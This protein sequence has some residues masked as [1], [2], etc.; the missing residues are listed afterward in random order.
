MEASGNSKVLKAS[1]VYVLV[2]LINKG[3]GIITVP[4]FTR[5]LSTAEMGVT[6]TWISWMTILLPITTLSLVTAS[7]YIAFKEYPDK[8]D[9]YQSS[10]LVLSTL[11]TFIFLVIYLI[12]HDILNKVFTLST[13]LM[14][15]MFLYLIFSPAL[16][17]WMLRQRYEYKT[18]QM[19]IVTLISNIMA[20][21]VAVNLVLFFKESNYNLGTLRVYGTYAVTGLFGVVFYYKILKDGR[22]LF[23]REFWK[24]GL[25]ISVPLIFHTLAKNLLDISDRSMISIFNG[26]DAVG[27]Y[28]TIYSISTLSLIVWTA[29]NNAFIPY[30]Y[31]KL[32]R[33]EKKGIADV[34]QISYIMIIIYGGACIILT[35]IAPEIVKLLT[36]DAY[37]E[38]VHIMPPVAAGIFLTCVYN[39]FANVILF[40]KKSVGVMVATMIA[41]VT[42]IV[43]NAI[44]IPKFGYIAAAYTTLVAYIILSIFQ[45]GVMKRV[46]KDSLYNMSL[47]SIIS[48]IV[49]LSCLVFNILYSMTAIRYAIIIIFIVVGAINYKK[50]IGVLNMLKSKGAF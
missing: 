20:S 42:N 10:V 29:I 12:F 1:I 33:N 21:F 27:I 3:I 8:R 2:S 24:F 31:D 35:A 49:V 28:G 18:K 13:D 44:F 15:F 4:V 32:E 26:K 48:V 16:D 11:S 19:A 46:H 9:S 7:L 6:T 22:V 30:L 45:G 5:L 34:K 14:V 47:I 23:D 25:K 40:H 38:A 36:T 37:Y 39:L 41:A 43:L 17:M 50:T